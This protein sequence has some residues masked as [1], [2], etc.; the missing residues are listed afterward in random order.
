LASDSFKKSIEDRINQIK[1][2]DKLNNKT[3]DIT[4]LQEMLNKANTPEG[5]KVGDLGP[6]E[7][8]GTKFKPYGQ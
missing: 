7:L 1:A 6:A 5:Y 3:T 8:Y 2:D 4:K